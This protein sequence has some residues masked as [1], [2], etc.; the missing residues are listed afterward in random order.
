MAE[1]RAP[2]FGLSDEDF[3]ALDTQAR[4]TA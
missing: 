1:K 3:A 2:V 4:Q